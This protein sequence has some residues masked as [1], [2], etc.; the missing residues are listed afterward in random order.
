MAPCSLMQCNVNLKRNGKSTAA[1]VISNEMLKYG[2]ET[3]VKPL[4]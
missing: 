1:D 3:L 2:K 4:K